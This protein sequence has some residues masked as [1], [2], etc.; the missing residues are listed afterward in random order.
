MR[1][2]FQVLAVLGCTALAAAGCSGEGPEDESNGSGNGQ[3]S[4]GAGQ[5][6]PGTAGTQPTAP[7]G[8]SASG[9]AGPGVGG[10][11][12]QP[13]GGTPPVGTAGSAAAAGSNGTAGT[14]TGTGGSSTKPAI[15]DFAFPASV[16]SDQ[17]LSSS[18]EVDSFDGKMARF[19]GS[20]DLGSGGGDEGQDPLFVVKAGGTLKNVI[21]G[22]P[23][24]DG[25]HC[26]GSCTIENVWWEDVGEDAI[27]LKGS[28]SS[29]VYRITGGGA[30]K[31]TDKVIQ[32]N[33]GGTVYVKNFL[34]E[35]FGKLYRSCGNCGDQYERH[36]EFDTIVANGMK[37]LLAGVNQN[38]GDSAKLKNI[39]ADITMKICERYQG[40]DSGD[41]PQS[42]GSGADGTHCI[43]SDA[44]IAWH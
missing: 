41:E 5:V 15:P 36:A 31:A 19:I 21:L 25:V 1:N 3:P 6:S 35:D 7:A 14:S 4:S 10:S 42:I 37:S 22:A 28:S 29:N 32:H 24:A 26:E 38:Y 39:F 34:V 8:G 9:G 30:R 13:S 12:N 23:A 27:T 18:K 17:K 40:N 44:D 20:G 11:G 2:Y 43:Y 16:G 33:G